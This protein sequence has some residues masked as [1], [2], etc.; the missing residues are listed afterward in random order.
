MG[1]KDLLTK[2]RDLLTAYYSLFT[3][4]LLTSTT[5]YLLL[6]T[7]YLL[8]YYLPLTTYSSKVDGKLRTTSTGK[9]PVYAAGDCT[10]DRQF[11]HYAGFQGD[12][13]CG[14]HARC[15]VAWVPARPRRLIGRGWPRLGATPG[16]L[17]LALAKP[18]RVS[19]RPSRSETCFEPRRHRGAQRASA[20]RRYGHARLGARLH[21]HRAGGGVSA[22]DEQRDELL[23]HAT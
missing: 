17:S 22:I 14:K 3:S 5:Y 16:T 4:Y 1:A 21:L 6:T 10:G 19:C 2:I 23:P 15:G 9:V 20:P 18:V 7:Y 8:T 11:T 13:L 12:L